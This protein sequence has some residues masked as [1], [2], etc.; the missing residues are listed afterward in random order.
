MPD[1]NP[2]LEYISMGIYEKALPQAMAWPA[3]LAAARQAGYHFVEIAIDDTDDRLT[4]LDWGRP[5]RSALR[6]ASL[7]TGVPLLSLS[8]SAHRRYP[9]GS[10]SLETRRQALAILDKALDFSAAIGVRYLLLAGVDV[11]YEQSTPATRSFFLQGLEHAFLRASSAGIML[12]LENWDIRIDTLQQA[13]WY[14]RYFNSPWFQLYADIGNLVYA[15]HDVIAELEAA[16]GHIAA[17]HLKDTLPGQLRYVPL[18]QGAVP[19]VAAFQKLAEIGFQGPA[20][21]ELWTESYPDSLEIVAAARTWLQARMES[22]WTRYA[23]KVPA[24]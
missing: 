8:L 13:M 5:E 14:V 19:F 17:V 22:G 4:R 11:Y 23:R 16:R 15:G 1:W 2:S 24:L 7:D 6:A 12:A 3:R 9:L 18:G 20:C 21:V 10:L